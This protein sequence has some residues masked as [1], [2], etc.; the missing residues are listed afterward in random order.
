MPRRLDYE[1]LESAC[2]GSIT[3]EDKHTEFS[4][5][6]LDRLLVLLGVDQI[7]RGDVSRADLALAKCRARCG[8][9]RM[10]G[11]VLSTIARHATGELSRAL[12]APLEECEIISPVD[13]A[14]SCRIS[15]GEA[16]TKQ[17]K[18]TTTLTS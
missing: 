2:D 18:V 11:N 8:E 10:V 5:V 7:R 16:S 13:Q 6:L 14:Q 3:R 15:K 4:R 17:V 12:V 9:L 1:R